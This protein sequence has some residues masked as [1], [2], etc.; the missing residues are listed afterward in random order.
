MLS[1]LNFKRIISFVITH[2][3][4]VELYP[5]WHRSVAFVEIGS[6]IV[7]P[8]DICDSNAEAEK[9]VDYAIQEVKLIVDPVCDKCVPGACH[10]ERRHRG[11]LHKRR[12]VISYCF[13][14]LLERLSQ[15]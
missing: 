8:E 2:S 5:L 3:V 10:L 1:D 11:C 14:L 12:S 7:E 9:V 6:A 15:G 4:S 13:F